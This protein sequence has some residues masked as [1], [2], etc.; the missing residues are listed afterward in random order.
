MYV[1]KTTNFSMIKNVYRLKIVWALFQARI[2]RVGR[3]ALKI[4]KNNH[5]NLEYW[6]SCYYFRIFIL[7]FKIDFIKCILYM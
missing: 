2:Q 4:F 3:E 6:H 1:F 5:F 7:N